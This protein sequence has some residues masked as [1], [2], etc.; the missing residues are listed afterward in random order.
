M[1]HIPGF[2]QNFQYCT[3]KLQGSKRGLWP[4]GGLDDIR[5]DCI[6]LIQSISYTMTEFTTGF[7]FYA[8]L[9]ALDMTV[10][11][12]HCITCFKSINNSSAGEVEDE[13]P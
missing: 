4:L 9:G 10:I 3:L 7:V 5:D 12:H 1:I 8:T 6:H 2:L 11:R 13:A